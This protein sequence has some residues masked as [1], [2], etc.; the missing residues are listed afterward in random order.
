[1]TR[2][3]SLALAVM[4]GC[5]FA[6]GDYRGTGYRCAAGESCP[7]GFQCADGV[8]IAH[9]AAGVPD[10]R[11]AGRPDAGVTVECP[12]NALTNPSFEAGTA[13]WGGVGGPLTQ[14]SEAHDG[15]HAAQRCFDGSDT[16][17]NIN[18]NPDSVMG[19][20][21]GR[22]YAASG[23]LRSDSDQTVKAVIR[24]KE[25]SGDPIEYSSTALVLKPDWQEV[26]VEHTIEKPAAAAVE[27]Y[28]SVDSA[29]MGDCFQLDHVCFRHAR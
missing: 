13:G 4:A 6:G 19:T 22:R 11:L 3:L 20:E 1:V 26:T 10:A 7:D 14:V 29:V 5:S 12:D 18:D 27:V 16:Y 25:S 21:V 23:W 15:E 17:Y 9:D 2:A 8:C 28:F 24:V